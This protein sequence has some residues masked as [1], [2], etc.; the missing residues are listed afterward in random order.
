MSHRHPAPMLPLWAAA[1]FSAALVI[2]APAALAQAAV[3]GM[4]RVWF[5]QDRNPYISI[6]YATVAMNG[7]VIGA[8]PP[9]GGVI[10]RD[11]APGRYHLTVES[12]GVDVNQNL[13]VDLGPGQEVYVKV[14]NLPDWATPNLGS[15]RR[16]TF[17]LRLLPP[18]EARHQLAQTPG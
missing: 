14:L 2:L 16:D 15:I 3:T 18:A 6:N 13:D 12:A 8:V 1:W 10:S 9:Y 5:F 17:Y 11:V 7:V 4:A